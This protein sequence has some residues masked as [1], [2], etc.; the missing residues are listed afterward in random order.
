LGLNTDINHDI[1]HF[2]TFGP[3]TKWPIWQW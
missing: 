1:Q 2:T 3:E